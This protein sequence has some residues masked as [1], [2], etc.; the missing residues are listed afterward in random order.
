MPDSV[1]FDT[2]ILVYTVARNDPRHEKAL[3]L[4]GAGGVV[5][6]QVLN[7]FVSVVRRKVQMPWTEV[8]ATMNW[9]RVLCPDPMTLSIGTHEEALRIAERYG[10]QI[11][12]SLMISSALESNCTTLYSEGMQDGQLIDSRLRIR[13]PFH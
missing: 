6:V 7:E 1:F 13:N 3:A 12:D 5:S 2:N 11:Y 9:F 4:L 10:Y 8:A